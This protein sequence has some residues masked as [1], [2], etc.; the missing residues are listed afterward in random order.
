MRYQY[1]YQTDKGNFR[2]SNQDSLLVTGIRTEYGLALLAA[3]CDGVGGLLVGEE[4]SRQTAE[5]LKKWTEYELPL[6]LVQKDCRKLM[7]YRFE[8]LV[9]AINK[10]IYYANQQ[11][12]IVSGTTLSAMLLWDN[13]YV[14][15]HVGDS[16]IYRIRKDVTQMTT[17]HSL[18]ACEVA[19]GRITQEEAKQDPRQ[20]VI[21]QSIGNSLKINPE[22]KS[23]SLSENQIF[24]LCTDG[25]WHLMETEEWLSFFSP[26]IL[27]ESEQLK[28]QISHLIERARERGEKD[29]ITAIA[30]YAALE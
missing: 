20:N 10:E 30:V 15:G 3:V 1:S 18:V 29:N 19:A 8:Q 7:E 4:T 2:V 24:V 26:D 27:R 5:L 28:K 16:R 9:Q 21:T 23:G 25:F 14:I 6:I 13:H 17:D 11:K 12:G 22:I